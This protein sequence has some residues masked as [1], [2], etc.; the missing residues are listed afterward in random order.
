MEIRHKNTLLLMG[1]I[2]VFRS[3]LQCWP[4]TKK[5]L[6]TYLCCDFSAPQG[7]LTSNHVRDHCK[8]YEHIFGRHGNCKLS[9]L[10]LH[11]AFL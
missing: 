6:E 9:P 7:L 1:E 5:I 8:M 11:L 10:R 4:L 2:E 3:A